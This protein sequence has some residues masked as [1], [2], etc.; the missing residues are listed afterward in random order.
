[1]DVSILIARF[2]G[3]VML[4]A[5]LSMFVNRA[6]MI[7][8]FKDFTD[9]P[10]MIFI[11]GVMA[12]AL[13]IALVTFHNIWAADWRVFI[14]VY[15]WLALIG[16]VVR[17]MFPDIAINLGRRIMERPA[18]LTVTAALNILIGGFLAYQGFLA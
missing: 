1:M 7:E 4:L 11:G 16:G 14:T 15:G 8:I 10:G 12:L 9:S 3:P 18:F 2:I 17:M 13:G 5:G 6:R